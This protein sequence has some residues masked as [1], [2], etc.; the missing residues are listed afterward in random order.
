MVELI[1]AVF[2]QAAADYKYAVEWMAKNDEMERPRLYRQM[3]SLR[4]EVIRFTRS[5]FFDIA[6]GDGISPDEFLRMALRGHV[7]T[8]GR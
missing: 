7:K 1:A 6:I 8:N 5:D 3:K 2:K 4:N